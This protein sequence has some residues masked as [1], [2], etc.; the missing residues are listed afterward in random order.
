M[1]GPAG[2]PDAEFD[3]RPYRS[4]VP[5]TRQPGFRSFL[6][7]G[8]GFTAVGVVVGIVAGALAGTS[9][10]LSIGVG[11]AAF[12]GCGFLPLVLALLARP[13]R[14]LT[15]LRL[16]PIGFSVTTS[17]GK[18]VRVAWSDPDLTLTFVAGRVPRTAGGVVPE[19][20][21]V[22]P[23][24]IDGMVGPEARAA[25][26]A[27]AREHGF[28]ESE[29]SF[30][31]KPRERG[32]GPARVVARN[33]A[34]PSFAT[35]YTEAEV[36]APLPA[37]ADDASAGARRFDLSGVAP[38]VYAPAAR[39]VPNALREIT[40]KDGGVEY[41]EASGRQGHRGWS[42]PKLRLELSR[43]LA[44]P[45]DPLARA[46]AAWRVTLPN[47]SRSGAVDGRCYAAIVASA[48]RAGL[49]V[50]TVRFPGVQRPPRFWLAV[51]RIRRPE[52]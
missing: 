32:L 7:V 37:V 29:E 48:E 39:A 26:L 27:A 38:P 45:I 22:R 33:A 42:D 13:G 24:P 17:A 18:T 5:F 3:L 1:N 23:A 15:Q 14:Y 46:S 50:T 25:L 30:L 34:Q 8:L 16:D 10:L 12:G 6:S 52:R 9:D 11:A 20:W 35:A 51:T 28:L 41:T 19:E 21:L 47:E 36:A 2:S 43:R 40:V 49:E 31:M 44:S 4:R